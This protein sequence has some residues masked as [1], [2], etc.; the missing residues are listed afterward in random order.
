MPQRLVTAALAALLTWPVLALGA[1]ASPEQLEFFEKK[2]RPV[3]VRE[4]YECH[5]AGSKQVK[6][7]LLLDTRDAMM[8]GGDSGPAIVPGNAKESTLIAALKQESFEMPPKGKLSDEVIADFVRWVE[9]GAADPRESETAETSPRSKI[10]IAK[11]RQYWAFQPPVRGKLPE[12]KDKA[13]PKGDVD[14]YI[15]AALESRDL[16]PVSPATRRQLIRRATFDLTG[17]PPTPAEIDAF[18]ADDSAQ[19]FERV[20][21]RLLASPHYGERWGRYW[22]DVARYAEDQAH[23]FGVKPN[24]SGYRYR[25]WVIDALNSDMPYDEFVKR[26]IAGD[27]LND[28][29]ADAARHVAALGYFGL[30]AQYYKNSD[31][32]KASADEL[33]DRVDT[34][35]RGFLGLT[36]SCAR[37]HDHKFDPIP[38]QDYYSLAGVFQSCKL[39]NT[40][41]ATKEEVQA[42]DSAQAKIRELENRI[43]KF[44]TDNKKLATDAEITQVPKYLQAVWKQRE[45]EKYKKPVKLD[46]LAKQGNLRESTLKKW[47]ELVDPKNRGKHP[48]FDA[49]FDLKVAEKDAADELLGD[50]NSMPQEVLAASLAVQ[51]CLQD[52]LNERDGKAPGTPLV[53]VASEGLPKYVSPIFSGKTRSAEIDL[54]ITGAKQLYL[55]VTDGGDGINSDHADWGDPRIV[56]PEG[57][58][59]LTELKWKSARTGYAAVELNKNFSKA[60]IQIDGRKFEYGIGTHAPAEVV[61][62]L[63]AGCTRFKATVGL[64]HQAAGSIQFRVYIAPPSDIKL[65]EKN[66]PAPPKLSQQTQ[67]LLAAVFGEKGVMAVSDGELDR[68]LAPAD[69]KMFGDMK[70]DFEDSKKNAP[71]MYAVAH[72]IADAAPTDMKVFIRGNPARQ[73]ELAPRRFLRVLSTDEPEKFHDGSGRRELAEAIASPNN[74]LTARVMI[75]RL[76]QH[77]FGRGLVGT[78]SNFGSLGEQPT[79]PELLDYLAVRFVELGWSIKAIHRELMLSATYQLSSSGDAKNEQSDADNRWLWR[80]NRERLDVESW[81][82]SLLAVSGNLDPQLGGPSTDLGQASNKRRTVYAKI[83]RHELDGL[84]R[85]FDFPDANITSDKRSETTVPQQQLFVLNSPFMIEQA[86]ALAARL[87][88]DPALTD[89]PARVKQVFL[90]AYGRPATAEEVNLIVSYLGGVDADDVKSAN[91]LTRWE[92]VAQAMLGANEFMYVD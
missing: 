15:L 76:W 18:L 62:D 85:L 80:M 40:P 68:F 1:D 71:P 59:K 45:G 72:G 16:K 82:D 74:P 43:K 29:P 31:A 51:K 19:A 5:A 38:T 28:K 53:A 4:C 33:D 11:G 61:Y 30:G 73:G 92:R 17:L 20:V 77:H 3:L 27:Q 22:L 24:T 70:R 83:S 89:D 58:Q 64:D 25:D 47:I 42:Y 66:A 39:V 88:K 26:Q 21:D 41:L 32:A 67:D 75:N 23:T 9:Q 37:C 55:V 57:E 7:G 84:L 46:E 86:K 6:G 65:F 52:A 44:T 12:V 49:W 60:P 56:G 14:H 2:I 36:V 63:P 50:G 87:Q 34:L 69:Q 13:W 91:K 79:H 8:R 48:A 10:D 81:R 78:P 90:L 54:D 35:T